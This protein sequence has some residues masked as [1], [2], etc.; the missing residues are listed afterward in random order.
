MA[1]IDSIRTHA[2]AMADFASWTKDFDNVADPLRRAAR[3]MAALAQVMATVI[4][5]QAAGVQALSQRMA[6]VN[7]AL[8]QVNAAIWKHKGKPD[9]DIQRLVAGETPEVLDRF[10]ELLNAEGVDWSLLPEAKLIEDQN[11]YQ[12][13]LWAISIKPPEME[14]IKSTLQ[15]SLDSLSSQ[16][17]SD[18]ARVQTTLGRYNAVFEL[19]SSLIKKS[20]TQGDTV[21]TNLKT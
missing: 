2:D 7:D 19:V 10:R 3:I 17:Q 15:T 18:Q 5:T 14:S 16:S 8:K 20:E 6:L 21:S 4:D 9:G 1:L 12:Y 13:G 11:D